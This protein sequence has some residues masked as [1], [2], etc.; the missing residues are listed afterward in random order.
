MNKNLTDKVSQLRRG[1]SHKHQ[2]H[3][4]F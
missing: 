2:T 1:R 3:C 4:P